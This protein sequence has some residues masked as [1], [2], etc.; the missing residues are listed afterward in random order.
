MISVRSLQH[1]Y[2]IPIIPIRNVDINPY[3]IDM[4]SCQFDMKKVICQ[5]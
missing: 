5:N 2:M 1:S 4:N 3:H